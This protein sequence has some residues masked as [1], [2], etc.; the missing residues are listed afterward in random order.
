MQRSQ[1]S[2]QSLTTY[3]DRTGHSFSIESGIV[4][5]DALQRR[6]QRARAAR[7]RHPDFLGDERRRLADQRRVGQPLR[8]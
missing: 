3:H 7:N 5:A 8:T 1:P 2:R 4:P 6:D